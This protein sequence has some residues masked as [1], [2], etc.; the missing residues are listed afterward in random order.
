MATL[1]LNRRILLVGG[2]GVV[3]FAPAG[4][5][6][7]REAAISWDVPNFDRQLA[8]TLTEKNK[9]K[10]VLVLFDGADQAY[11]KEENVPKLSPLDRPRFIKRKLELAFPS[12]PI[13]AALEIKAAKK[14][15]FQVK[16]DDTPPSYLFVALPET[17][18]LDRVG[19]ALLES[20]V[21]VAGFGLLPVESAGLVVEIAQNLFNPEAKKQK[22]RK[23]S[24]WCVLIGQH[25]TGGLRQVV[26]KDGNLALARLTPTSEA[27]TSGPGWVE[28]VMRGFKETLAYVARFGYSA[29][30]GIDVVIV[31]GEIEKQFFDQKA[32]PV[33]NFRCVNPGEALALIGA[34]SFGLEKTNFADAL[35]AAWAGRKRAPAL[36]VR[37]PSIH[38]IM[39][40]RLGARFAS[41]ALVVTALAMAA[42]A[43]NDYQAYLSLDDDLSAKENRQQMAQREFDQESKA[44]DSLPVKPETLKNALAVKA[45]LDNNSVDPGPILNTLKA[46]LGGDVVLDKLSFEHAPGAGMSSDPKAVAAADKQDHGRVK[47]AFSFALPDALPLEQKVT[48]AEGLQRDLKKAFPG[49][50]VKIAQQFGG[51]SRTGEFM[52]AFAAKDGEEKPAAAPTPTENT[53]SFTLEGAP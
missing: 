5:G 24:R 8:E 14:K 53:A 37:I 18:Q 34:K 25:E 4:K 39:A 29:D 12:Y 6:V 19:A 3:L 7:E 38:R 52:G 16:A 15:G 49:W 47:I 44:F 20:S 42:L 46:T 9:N 17:E 35:H 31:C 33:T 45:L 43:V 36:P 50:E 23:G 51:I 13:R 2:E 26:V 30:E 21:P 40:P 32:M 11:R 28:E 48:R 27:G 1:P 41:V 22:G 10:S